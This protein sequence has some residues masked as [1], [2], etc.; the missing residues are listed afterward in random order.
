MEESYSDKM[1]RVAREGAEVRKQQEKRH[2]FTKGALLGVALSLMLQLGAGAL[3]ALWQKMD[4]SSVRK[5]LSGK[6][7]EYCIGNGITD[8]NIK[9]RL[10]NEMLDI[11]ESERKQFVTGSTNSNFDKSPEQ[12]GSLNAGILSKFVGGISPRE[13]AGRNAMHLFERSQEDNAELGR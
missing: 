4:D 10:E 13:I 1:A 8:E 5:Q 7:T 3:N 9:N 2:L 12:I 6:V 11:Y